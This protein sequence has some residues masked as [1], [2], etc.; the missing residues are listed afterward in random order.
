MNGR[1]PTFLRA[2]LMLCGE[3]ACFGSSTPLCELPCPGRQHAAYFPWELIGQMGVGDNWGEPWATDS[4]PDGG[5][6]GGSDGGNSGHAPPPRGAW[7]GLRFLAREQEEHSW[8]LAW[9]RG[10]VHFL[11]LQ[12]RAID[13][14]TVD[15]W[16][17]M[18]RARGGLGGYAFSDSVHRDERWEPGEGGEDSDGE[19]V[20][21]GRHLADA[22]SRLADEE[23]AA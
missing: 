8:C 20:R 4:E 14:G 15:E 3:G 12:R 23:E 7:G 13:L 17:A 6:D 10:R 9:H 21:L 22:F 11:D 2:L 16:R 19:G 18:E 5:S 1:F